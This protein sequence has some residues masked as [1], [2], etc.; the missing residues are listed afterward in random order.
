MTAQFIHLHLHSAYSL[1]EGAIPVSRLKDLCLADAMPA[2]A[3]TDTNNLFGAL[4]VSVTLAGAGIQPIIGMQ[5]AFN[6]VHFGLPAAKGGRMPG[7]VLLAQNEAGYQN[8]LKITSRAFLESKAEEGVCANLDWLE[9]NNDGL[10]C[11]TGGYD[12]PLNR[13]LREDRN[14]D[15]KAALLQLARLFPDRL[16]VEIQRHEARADDS[17]EAPLIDLAYEL[18]LP[19]VATN[20]PFF[21]ARDDYEAH[22]ALLCVA[23]GA[24]VH[25]DDRRKVTPD[26]YFKTST[27]MVSLFSDVPEAI[28]NTLEI[29]QRCAFRPRFRDPILPSFAT[30]GEGADAEAMELERQAREGLKLRLRSIE[31]AAPESDYWD[32]LKIELDIINRMGFPGYFLIVADF[33]QWSKR[34]GVPVGP[35]RGSGAGSLVAWSLT[36]TDLDPL[37]FGLLFE[38]FLNPERVS[39]PDFDIDFCQ[40]RRDEVIRY[41]QDKYGRDRVAQII[42]FGK[43]Q[44]RAVLRDVGRVQ[45]MSFGHVDRVCKLIPNNPANPVTLAEALETEPRLKELRD[46]DEA[47]A[48]LIEKALKL[49]GLYRHASTHAAGVVIGDRPLDELVPLYR[50]PRSDMPATQFNMK[51]VEP[52]GLVK[53]DFLG[54]KTLTVIAKAVGYAAERGVELIMSDIPLDDKASFEM[55]GEGA[56]TGVFQLESTGMRSTLRAMKPDTLEDIIALVSL[57]RPGPMENIPTYIERKQGLQEPDYLHPLLE[58]VLKETYG[59]IIYQEQVMQIAQILSGYSLGE[60]DLL[61]RAMGKKKKEEMD[62][63]RKRFID[64]AKEKNVDAAKASS[65]FDLVQKFAG[66]GFNKSHAAAYA[67]IAY[68]TAWL[69]ANYP[70]EFLAASMSLDRTNT[71]KLATFLK[72]ARRA[73]VE[74]LPPHIN[75][76]KADFSVKDG[77][78]VYALSAIKNVGEGAMAHIAEECSQNG[79]F[80]D[81]IDFAERVDLKLIGKRSLENLAR[82]GALDGLSASRAQGFASAELLLRASAAHQEEQNSDQ[83]GLFALDSAPTLAKPK[84]PIIEEWVPQVRLDEERAAVGFYFSGHPLDDYETELKRLNVVTYSDAM[85]RGKNGRAALQMAGVIRTVRMRRSK[86]GKPFAWVELSDQS[87]EFEITVFSETLNAARDLMEA[88]ALVLVGVTVEDRDGDIRFTCE[89]MRSLNAAAA[90]SVSQLRVSVTSA[91][92]LEGLKRRLASVRPASS[93]ESGSV[94]VVMRLPESGREI[95]LALPGLAACTPAMRG[96]LRSIHGVSDVELI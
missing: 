83:G 44:A 50:D 35:G 72:E 87:G 24:Y 48:A 25:Q 17:V 16:Y 15:A 33:I 96:A 70:A 85:T 41:V 30:D 23:E 78:I 13:L 81:L 2:V 29:A 28:E 10:I 34:H 9:D 71:D 68:Q 43:L 21:P 58:G 94:V 73:G 4:E 1:A 91:D 6:P 40:D 63:Q 57:Y 27:E 39:M 49:E 60:A 11:L 45:N 8:L 59:V 84:L 37:R 7:L 79:P 90:A 89:T 65:I 18:D 55:L 3:V 93:N 77:A 56:A 88:G 82:A 53:F 36:I 76:S 19:L 47:V 31:L 86:S 52:A 51:W 22:D 80:R 69:K 32:R 95:D 67:Y 61:R 74:V 42:T 64:G 66:Y 92:A 12:G 5:Q 14:A 38:R 26:H 20:E 62:Q 75:H 54:L 46:D